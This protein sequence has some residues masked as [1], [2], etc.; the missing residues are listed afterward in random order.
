MTLSALFTLVLM[1]AV[2]RL[3]SLAVI[4]F[5]RPTVPVSGDARGATVDA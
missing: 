1:P 3:P 2:L 4:S 5:R